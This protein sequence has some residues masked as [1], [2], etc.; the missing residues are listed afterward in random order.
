[1]LFYYVIEKL[2]NLFENLKSIIGWLVFV[3]SSQSLGEDFNVQSK[4]LFGL[5]LILDYTQLIQVKI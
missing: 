1:M 4:N 2:K 5:T 3:T